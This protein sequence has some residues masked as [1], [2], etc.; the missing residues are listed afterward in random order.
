VHVSELNQLLRSFE[1]IPENQI[2]AIQKIAY[3]LRESGDRESALMA[4]ILFAAAGF[5]VVGGLDLEEFS[6]VVQDV[7]VEVRNR[8][9]QG[10]N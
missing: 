10:R 7:V 9:T 8:H 3:E 5:G 4:A 2:Q 6:T 1:V